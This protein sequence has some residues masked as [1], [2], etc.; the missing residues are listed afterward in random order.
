M[1]RMAMRG[2]FEIMFRKH[3]R[4]IDQPGAACR[5]KDALKLGKRNMAPVI[6]IPRRAVNGRPNLLNETK[7]FRSESRVFHQIAR[8]TNELGRKFVDRPHHFPRITRV[9]FVMEIGEMDKA[10]IPWTSTQI[11]FRHAQ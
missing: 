8:E 3:H 9:P 6:V 7:R 11:Q 5:R 2:N 1:P 4:T 10:A